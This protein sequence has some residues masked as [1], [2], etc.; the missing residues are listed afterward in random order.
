MDTPTRSVATEWEV[1]LKKKY[2]YPRV[3][4]EGWL[5]ERVPRGGV[6]TKTNI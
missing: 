1:R 5:S 3:E 2:L 6:D 4:R